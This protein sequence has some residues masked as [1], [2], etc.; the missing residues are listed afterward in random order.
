MKENQFADVLELI[1]MGLSSGLI[2]DEA[3]SMA[4]KAMPSLGIPVQD[5]SP[6]AEGFF[7]VVLRQPC[8]RQIES[9]ILII[10]E[11]LKSGAPLYEVLV[12]QASFLREEEYWRLEQRAQTMGLKLLFPIIVFIFP[13]IFILLLGSIYLQI[14]Q[15][16]FL[17]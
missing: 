10:R 9:I 1:A 8:S 12:E 17:F 6:G 5:P 4:L 3:C 7:E 16:G 13:G 15:Q 2:L 14:S 11:A